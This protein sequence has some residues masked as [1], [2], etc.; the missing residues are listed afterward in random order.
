A[1]RCGKRRKSQNAGRALSR[2]FAF[3]GVGPGV[4]WS[5][6]SSP[7]ETL[8]ELPRKHRA[9][10]RG[11]RSDWVRSCGKESRRRRFS[12]ASLS[13]PGGDSEKLARLLTGAKKFDAEKCAAEGMWR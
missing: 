5:Q 11:R 1:T 13:N 4:R 7:S 2:R 3:I 10:E 9:R 6:A 12:F 8:F